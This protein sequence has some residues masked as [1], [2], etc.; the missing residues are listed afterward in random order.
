MVSSIIATLKEEKNSYVRETCVESLSKIGDKT[1]I[2]FLI[3]LLRDKDPQVRIE[4]SLAVG[5]M[6]TVR[7]VQPSCNNLS[8][9]NVG[10]R[11][12]AVRAIE[13]IKDAKAAVLP[14]ISLLDEE[15]EKEPNIR[16]WAAWTL[17][18]IGDTRAIKALIKA[19]KRDKSPDVRQ[20]AGLALEEIA[21]KHRYSKEE[22]L[23]KYN[24]NNRNNS[25]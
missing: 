15:K 22:L 7:A 3:S 19:S 24:C 4:A 11:W 23:T 13:A 20:E 17:G 5:K 9:K 16:D 6:K 14:L 25:E 21:K 1:T 10:V 2:P 8:A 12:A 18:E